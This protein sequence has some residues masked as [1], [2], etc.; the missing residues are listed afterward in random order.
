MST[1]INSDN[2]HKEVTLVELIAWVYRD[3]LAHEMSHHCL[4]LSEQCNV[5]SEYHSL[6]RDGCAQLLQDRKLGARIPTTLNQQ[7]LVLHAD[8]E[9]LHRQ[10]CQI[11][12]QDPYGAL[13]VFRHARHGLIPDYCHDIPQPQ[14]VYGLDKRGRERIV[15]SVC[16]AGDGHVEQRKITDPHS[17]ETR[18]IWV[19]VG[20]AYCP[21]TYWPSATSVSASRLDYRLWFNALTM[22]WSQLPQLK[23]WKVTGMGAEAAPWGWDNDNLPPADV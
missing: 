1:A 3:Q 11:S 14:P 4:N 13:L 2:V 9:L 20:Y 6:S 10:L 19:E 21:I 22:L 7:R 12:Q 17:G 16:M 5:D 15:H 8:A 23:S 18:L